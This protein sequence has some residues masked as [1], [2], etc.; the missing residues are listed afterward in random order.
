MENLENDLHL[1]PNDIVTVTEMGHITEIQYLEHMNTEPQIR[2][3]SATHYADL[4]TGEIKEF[5]QT[6]NRSEGYKSL[7]K[8]F[9]KLRYLINNN[10]VG[11]RNELFCTLT[12]GVRPRPTLGDSKRIADDFKLFFR[13]LKRKYGHID[14]VRVLEPH[15]DG[16]AHL[17]VLLRFNEHRSVFI[18]NEEFS[19]YWQKGFVTV[20]SLKNVDNIGAYVSAYLTDIEVDGKVFGDILD[21]NEHVEVIEKEDK[22]YVKGG[23]LKYYPRGVQIYNK[24]KGIVEPKRTKM[25]YSEAKKIVGSGQPTFEKILFVEKDDFSNKIKFE[26]YNSKRL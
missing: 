18:K 1:R 26:Q 2:K 7:Y 10:F 16:H 13:R 20:H 4:K 25:R 17:H 12:Y 22:K 15:A 6:N 5:Q 9:K 24:S 23:R 8:T 14:F 3:L 11:E 21:K 19:S